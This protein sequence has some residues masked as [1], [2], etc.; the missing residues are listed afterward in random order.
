MGVAQAV[1]EP[2]I[3]NAGEAG[4]IARTTGTTKELVSEQD[5]AER[6]SWAQSQLFF[7]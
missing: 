6:L 4:A 1:P 3:V 5:L 2:V 7:L